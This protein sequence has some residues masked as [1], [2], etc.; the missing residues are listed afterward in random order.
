MIGACEE[1]FLSLL[2]FFRVI[3]PFLAYHG[4]AVY[5]FAIIYISLLSFLSFHLF[6]FSCSFYILER[7]REKHYIVILN[8]VCMVQNQKNRRMRI[9]ERERGDKLIEVVVKKRDGERKRE[10]IYDARGTASCTQLEGLK[11]KVVVP[12]AYWPDYPL[13]MTRIL[14]S[15]RATIPPVLLPYSHPLRPTPSIACKYTWTQQHLF[16]AYS[17]GVFSRNSANLTRMQSFLSS[18]LLSSFLIYLSL[19]IYR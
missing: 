1:D 13:T 16:C 19:Y 17:A 7:N 9:W 8:N 11:L 3:F 14:V 4:S 6:F 12:L 2:F 18:S 15:H 5:D 10:I